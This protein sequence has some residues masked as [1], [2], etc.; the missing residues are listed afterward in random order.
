MSKKFKPILR[1]ICTLPTVSL[2]IM[3]S[4]GGYNHDHV[5]VL[6]VVLYLLTIMSKCY[7][8]A[9]EIERLLRM[10]TNFFG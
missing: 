1:H 4:G 10:Y 2:L 5:P 6:M 8:R 3:K 7:E 9:N